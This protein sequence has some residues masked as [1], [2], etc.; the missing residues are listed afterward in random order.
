MS[1]A[2]QKYKVSDVIGAEQFNIRLP[3]KYYAFSVTHL[4]VAIF[5]YMIFEALVFGQYVW[6]RMQTLSEV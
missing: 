3:I 5:C 2:N 4:I 6:F 1:N